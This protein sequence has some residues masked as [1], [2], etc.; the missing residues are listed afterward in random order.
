MARAPEYVSGFENAAPDSQNTAL[1]AKQMFW[2]PN[3]GVAEFF[4]RSFWEAELLFRLSWGAQRF[5]QLILNLATFYQLIL[6]L[7]ELV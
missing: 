6:G 1:D 2:T 5:F 7:A 3:L 4:Q